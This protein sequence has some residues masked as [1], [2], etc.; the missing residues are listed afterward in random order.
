MNASG[1]IPGDPASDNGSSTIAWW[2]QLAP[3][4]S[5][6][7]NEHYQQTPGGSD[8]LRASGASWQQMALPGR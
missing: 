3:S 1:Y 8:T 5:G 2:R 4:V 7:L 6:L